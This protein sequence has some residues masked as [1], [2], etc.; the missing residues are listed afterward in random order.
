MIETEAKLDWINS[1]G[2]YEQIEFRVWSGD[3]LRLARVRVAGVA[4]ALDYAAR[5]IR[6]CHRRD[7]DVPQ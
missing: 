3:R 7:P 4:L 6:T 2:Q 1:V 5:Q